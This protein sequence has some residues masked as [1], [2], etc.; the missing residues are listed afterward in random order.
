M[1]NFLQ[2]NTQIDVSSI[3]TLNSRIFITLN[4]CSWPIPVSH[5]S[6]NKC[7][8]DRLKAVASSSY[9]ACNTGLRSTDRPVFRYATS[10]ELLPPSHRRQNQ[11]LI[12]H[13]QHFSGGVAFRDVNQ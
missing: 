2:Q 3:A 1:Q 11:I 8:L 9:V 13:N 10:D 4:D 12:Q 6:S 5:C 7:F